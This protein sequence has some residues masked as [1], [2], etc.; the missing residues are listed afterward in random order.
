[1][2]KRNMVKGIS[3]CNP[4]DIKRDYLLY[5]V[6]YAIN[7]G[8][9][10]IQ[11]IGPIHNPVKGNIDGMTIYKKYSQFND[12]K[13]MEF[14]KQ[15]MSYVNEACE[16]AH[17]A[18]VKTY[19][20]HH[21]LEVPP[22]F[23]ETYPEI[24]N[25][26]GDAEVTH[27]V[28][29]DFLENKLQDFFSEY[30]LIDGI[31]LTLH[32][33]RIPLLKLKNQKLDKKDRV[34]YVTQILYDTCKSLGKELIV[35][36]FASIDEDYE[37]MLRAFEEISTELLVMDKWTQFDW[38]LTLPHN[39]FFEKIKK[40][41]LFVETDI[42]GEFF[43]KGRLP[44]MLKKHIEEKFEYCETFNPVG[45]VSRI[46]RGTQHPFGGVNEVNINIMNACMKNEDVDCA[47]ME[48]FREKYPNAAEEVKELMM[49]TEDILRKII[50]LQ[51]YY[52][53][54]LS[55]FPSLN[56]SKNHFYFEMMRDDYC[57]ASEEWF[58]PKD[59][60][61]GSIESILN[62]KESAYREATAL[63]EKLETLKDRIE[64]ND[65]KPLWEKFAN[66]KYTA[67]IWY[68]LTKCFIH[69]AKYFETVDKGFREMLLE[70]VSAIRALNE[71]GKRAVGKGFYCSNI[72]IY[73][74]SDNS[75][76]LVE[77]FATELLKTL[78]AEER[79]AEEAKKRGFI[80]FIVC[81]GAAEGHKLKKEV[82]FSDCVFVDGEICRIPGNK[83]GAD[84]STV[85]THGW[86][87][88]EVK[89]MPN[90]ENMI[91][92][93]AGSDGGDLSLIVTIG[94]E[95]HN[96][97]Q[98]GSDKKELRFTYNETEGRDSVR[99]RIDRM[100]HFTPYIFSI[101]VSCDQ[102]N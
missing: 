67:A 97:A 63:F 64:E 87:S 28:I 40:N 74:D 51:G 33:T 71:E 90:C 6:D 76:E 98:S 39:R 3:V 29:R 96:V 12:S 65:Y 91:C 16:K 56:H 35:R 70:D 47:M 45:Y 36:T 66:L 1:M 57:I 43:G 83:R 93:T 60:K 80:D 55:A 89:V 37:M 20:W 58:V 5:T 85:N 4:I 25:S 68:E 84:W 15:T 2:E 48:F 101:G 27:P 19:V 94:D 54:E 46:D 42:F 75:A 82:C 18:G 62:E 13:N 53:S 10:H 26:Y 49:P 32:E 31:V 22:N 41:P 86:F 8:I 95:V 59:W 88:Y 50:Y 69:Y 14:V 44:L 11:F 102:N 72:E 92:V 24:C 7:H 79:M 23:I 61:R 81:G 34:K 78:E 9:D 100:T 73:D 38:S 30:P 21:E 77:A 17:K 99:I 52:F